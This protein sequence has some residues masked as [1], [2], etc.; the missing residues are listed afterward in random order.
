[1]VTASLALIQNDIYRI[2]ILTF[3]W[4]FL[5][6]VLFTGKSNV[7][8][9]SFIA[10]HSTPLFEQHETSSYL[11]KARLAFR[12]PIC[13]AVNGDHR[14]KDQIFCV[15]GMI[16]LQALPGCLCT[17]YSKLRYSQQLSAAF[18]CRAGTV[19]VQG[20]QSTSVWQTLCNVEL[21][22]GKKLKPQEMQKAEKPLW[23][24]RH[25]CMSYYHS[26]PPQLLCAP[27]NSLWTCRWG[28]LVSLLPPT[29]STRYCLLNL[30]AYTKLTMF[31]WNRVKGHK[32]TSW[33]ANA[34]S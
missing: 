30:Q 22:T 27:A 19:A 33:K 17:T 24:H 2:L 10:L 31:V 32:S 28:G 11:C 13:S 34:A 8:S 26:E 29:G 9:L 14:S 7:A 20:C 21:G 6:R 1:M 3:L 16:R 4:P 25:P 15:T 12:F 5:F 18:E 23:H